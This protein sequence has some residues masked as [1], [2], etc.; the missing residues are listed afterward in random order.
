MRKVREK[1]FSRSGSSSSSST[2]S[3][4]VSPTN[5]GSFINGLERRERRSSS[6]ERVFP[7]FNFP[8]RSALL[9]KALL[10]HHL[11][12]DELLTNGRDEC[13]IN[14]RGPWQRAALHWAS[15]CN[16]AATAEHLL[17]RGADVSIP[18]LLRFAPS[19]NHPFLFS[20]LLSSIFNLSPSPFLPHHS[21]SSFHLF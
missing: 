12:L 5:S 9:Y 14:Y 8:L 1:F 18:L 4:S 19:S 21:S 7:E 16:H 10:G 2:S 6:S 13:M 20:S 11:H 17:S 15:L 3:G